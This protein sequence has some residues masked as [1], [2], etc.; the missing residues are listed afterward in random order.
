ME[1][2]QQKRDD[3]EKLSEHFLNLVKT[4]DI[5]IIND[6]FFPK[7]PI[8]IK[9]E[10]PTK[11]PVDLNKLNDLELIFE[12]GKRKLEKIE[13]LAQETFT[14]EKI[15]TFAFKASFQARCELKYNKKVRDCIKNSNS[16]KKTN[17]C[18]E[19]FE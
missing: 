2:D 9:E 10:E 18:F 7:K 8:P 4:S 3:C 12:V 6:V 16:L 5:K 14:D 19:D 1:T 17:L 13:K 11:E 15:N